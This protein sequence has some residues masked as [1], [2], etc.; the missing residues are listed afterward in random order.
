[1]SSRHITQTAVTAAYERRPKATLCKAV[2]AYRAEAKHYG[3]LDKWA[4][5]LLE[6]LANSNEAAE[7]F[8]RLKL[9]DGRGRDFV[10]LC[11][12]TA[13]LA[14]MFPKRIS[15]EQDMSARLRRHDE[16]VRDLR[17]FV[18]NQM[19]GSPQIVPQTGSPQ[20]DFPPSWSLRRTID[21]PEEFGAMMR[22]LDLIAETIKKRR[23]IGE[24]VMREWRV[25][26]KK[27]HEDAGNIAAIR[28]LKKEVCRLTGKPHIAEIRK[29]VPVI[30]GR[31]VP[32][33]YALRAR[34]KALSTPK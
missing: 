9:K 15:S 23:H 25:T 1:M 2:N 27:R 19:T 29:F 12:F 6:R 4:L 3:K 34:K 28:H 32:S 5:E 14:R 16:A 22:G 24:A 31:E 18:K 10:M 30:F 13:E 20:T 11:I 8:E 33:Q 7:A 21:L 26:R 17:L